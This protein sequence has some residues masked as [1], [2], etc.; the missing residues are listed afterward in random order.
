LQSR[1]IFEDLGTFTLAGGL[2]EVKR[3]QLAKEER[4]R[5]LANS[6]S[7]GKTPVHDIEMG[8][9]GA[10]K[11][12]L[13][14]SEGAALRESQEREQNSGGSPHGSQ[15]DEP[16]TRSLMSP[17]SELG[18]SGLDSSPSEKARGKMRERR[19]L[20]IDA[21]NQLDRV[22][23]TIGRNGFV[24]TQEWVRLSLLFIR[25]PCIET[26]CHNFCRLLLGSRGLFI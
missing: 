15:A 9:P 6:D 5:K 12:R 10:E 25:R 26:S 21:I 16:L 4:A 24:P 22:P 13:L 8:D 20:S 18:P 19:S 23:L 11:A 1:K 14:E 7:K 2:R 17:T 3:A